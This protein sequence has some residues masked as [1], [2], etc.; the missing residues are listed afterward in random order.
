[1]FWL[2]HYSQNTDD[3]RELSANAV[4]AFH[5]AQWLLG[6]IQEFPE[7]S[8]KLLFAMGI[9]EDLFQKLSQEL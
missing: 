7:A 5:P 1:M 3:G 4:I 6:V 8:T 9:E 2:I